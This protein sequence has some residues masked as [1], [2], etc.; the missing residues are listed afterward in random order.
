MTTVAS[1]QRAFAPTRWTVDRDQSSVEFGV[2]TFWGLVTVH[3]RFDRFAGSYDVGPD[4]AEIELAIDAD[5]LDTGNGKRDE[6]LRSA[7]FFR[8]EE[9]P[10]VRFTSSRVRPA[11]DGMLEV[12]GDLRA[13]GRVV[14]LEFF[15]TVREVGGGLEIEATTTI[16]HSLLGMSSGQLGMIRAPASLHVKARLSR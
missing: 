4:G 2:R 9:H 5:S 8:V 14:P 1:E 13:A 16:D 6:H 7:A 11:G 12:E 3:G 15:A 10:Q